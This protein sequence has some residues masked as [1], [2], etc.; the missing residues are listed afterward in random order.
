MLRLN[1]IKV[2][3]LAGEEA[4]TEQI[5]RRL[6]KSDFTLERIVKK[7]IDAR[8]KTKLCYIYSVDVTTSGEKNYLSH[9]S[10]YIMLTKEAKYEFPSPNAPAE[11]TER[12]VIIGAGPA[13]YFAALYLARAGFKPVLY[14]RGADVDNRTNAVDSFWKG[15]RIDRNTNAQFGEGGAGTFSDGKLASGIKDKSGRIGAVLFDFVSFGAPEDIAYLAKPHIG[16]DRLKTVLKNMRSEIIRLGGEIHFNSYMNSL[17]S[18]ECGRIEYEILSE[19]KSFID[20]TKALILA[21]GHSSRETFLMLDKAGVPMES[22]PFAVGLRFEH[23]A[24][25]I[26]KGQYG[27]SDE[28][29]ALPAADYKMTYT[30]KDNRPVF[31]FCMCPGGYVINASSD[32]E[33][34]VVNGMSEYKRDGKFS[35]SAIVAGVNDSDFEAY[36]EHGLFAGMYF[37]KDMEKRAFDA[38]GGRIPVSEFDAFANGGSKLNNC[39]PEYINNAIIEGIVHYGKRLE[40]FDMPQALVYGVETRTSSPVRIIRDGNMMSKVTGLF[41]CG[42]GAGYAGGITS[43]AVDGIK[44]AEQVAKYLLGV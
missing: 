7:S 40:G 20:N 13:G 29:R 3:V 25:L 15:G 30:T 24:E 5:A 4:L 39:L 10:K 35:N 6:K 34:C 9:D 31:S 17:K 16:T 18:N 23:P 41:P 22:K 8:D 11:L 28:A 26:N 44:A 36:R 1:E 14:E 27:D 19:G 12:P 33:Q 21:I 2:P 32:D 38:G 43:A 42:E 37:Q